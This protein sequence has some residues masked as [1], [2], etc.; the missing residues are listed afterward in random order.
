[1]ISLINLI[2]GDLFM[3][4]YCNN[5]LVEENKRESLKEV[6]KRINIENEIKKISDLQ[7]L[8]KFVGVF[9]VSAVFVLLVVITL[10]GIVKLNL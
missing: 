2:E 3:C 8:C 5:N 6:R 7:N 10:L 9:V 1:V 4:K